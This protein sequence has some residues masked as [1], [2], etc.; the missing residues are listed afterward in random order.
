M[1]SYCYC[2][3]RTIV[4]LLFYFYRFVLPFAVVIVTLTLTL[5]FKE[6]VKKTL[7]ILA[8]DIESIIFNNNR[9]SISAPSTASS[10]D[11]I[12]N[13][14]GSRTTTAT[15]SS[16]SSSSSSLTKSLSGK[17]FCKR[18][19]NID[20]S[21]VTQSENISPS[22]KLHDNSIN[23]TMVQAV[24][25]TT[26]GIPHG[27]NINVSN[28]PSN[29]TNGSNNAGNGNGNLITING[30]MKE[31]NNRLSSPDDAKKRIISKTEK[32]LSASLIFTVSLIILLISLILLIVLRDKCW[33]TANSSHNSFAF[34]DSSSSASSES[35]SSYEACLSPV[36]VTSAAEIMKRIDLKV[37]PCVDFYKFS[38]G[39]IDNKLNPI[40]DDK[41]SMST[42]SLLQLEIDKKIRGKFC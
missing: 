12:E 41:S 24:D 32:I 39:G 16:S 15:S 2:L 7:L 17:I 28:L 20:I 23:Q 21:T 4:E 8:K 19:C 25:S 35:W 27:T 31:S 40:P 29:N 33:S 6:T 18:T 42:S 34:I 38:C 5:V 1:S 10:I 9:S 14:G 3:S 22:S 30:S 13:R 26:T 11:S 36:C 37:D